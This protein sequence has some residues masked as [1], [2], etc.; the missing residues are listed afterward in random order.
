MTTSHAAQPGLLLFPLV[1]S[2]VAVFAVK[3]AADLRL[4]DAMANGPLDV[5]EMAAAVS[6]HSPSLRRLLRALVPSGV[7]TEVEPGRFSLTPA[8]AS[9]RSDVSGSLLP[10][11]GMLER[12]ML[13]PLAEAAHSVQTGQ[14]AFERLFG[15]L[16]Y[17]YLDKQGQ[18][19]EAFTQALRSFQAVF[20]SVLEAYDFT[21]V[22]TVV[23][24]GGG[25]GG[26]LVEILHA[27]PE[28]GGVLFDRPGFAD[29]TRAV[30]P[31]RASPSAARSSGA[32][33]SRKCRRVASAI[34]SLW[35][36]PTGTT[37]DP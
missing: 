24:V 36:C 25:Q 11:L 2:L 18:D 16:F 28:L 37:P 5:D 22:R 1:Q 10:V 21:G 6:A 34:C 9:L 13:P 7:V 4:A 20:P 3:A 29:A 33:S 12:F 26:R 15:A 8:G 19:E 17:D 31:V 23:D 30:L 32:A 27:Y 35:C 14:A